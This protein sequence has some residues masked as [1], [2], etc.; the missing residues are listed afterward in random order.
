MMRSKSHRAVC[1]VKERLLELQLI[2]A[3]CETDARHS[4]HICAGCTGIKYCS[5]KCMEA[6]V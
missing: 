5:D 3:V 6:N 1:R 4:D 2:C